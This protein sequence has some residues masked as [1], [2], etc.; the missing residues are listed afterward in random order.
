LATTKSRSRLSPNSWAFQ[1]S[2]PAAESARAKA[3]VCGCWLAA[4][5]VE[6]AQA[7]G[8]L[9]R[10]VVPADLDLVLE[11]CAAIRLPDP[12]RTSELRQRYLRLVLDGL[13]AGPDEP[14]RRT[15]TGPL[16]DLRQGEAD[17]PDLPGQIGGH[18]AS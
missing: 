3:S 7:A 14:G 5:L 18:R 6:R 16:G 8:R 11:G 1:A 12:A 15:V 2:R 13:A 9:R 4:G 10:D 17:R